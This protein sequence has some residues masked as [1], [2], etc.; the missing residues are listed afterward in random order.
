MYYKRSL[1]TRLHE[2]STSCFISVK[3]IFPMTCRHYIPCGMFY[4]F[5]GHV[6]ILFGYI[7]E[8]N[9]RANPELAK[10][11]KSNVRQQVLYLIVTLH[12]RV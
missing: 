11:L 12:E 6:S 10:F 4:I 1:V 3:N 5:V 8:C 2:W 7:N 9:F